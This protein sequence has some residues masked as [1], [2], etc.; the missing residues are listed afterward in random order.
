VENRSER[1]EPG[2]RK[3]AVAGTARSIGIGKGAVDRK[4]AAS[5]Q[6]QALSAIVFLNREIL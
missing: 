1:P 5:T 2:C 4:V 3:P 6:N